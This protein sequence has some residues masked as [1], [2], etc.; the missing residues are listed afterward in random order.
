MRCLLLTKQFSLCLP[1]QMNKFQATPGA[2]A[3]CTWCPAGKET[4]DTGNSECT[5][6]PVGFY[7]PLTAAQSNSPACREAPA[8]TFVS[9]TGAKLAT[10]W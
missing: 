3:D 5:D 8:G 2:T 7:N 9:T 10:P 1:L 6:C 4:Q